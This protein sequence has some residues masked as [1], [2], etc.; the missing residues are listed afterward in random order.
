MKKDKRNFWI[1]IFLIII[2]NLIS[3]FIFSSGITNKLRGS[4]MQNDNMIMAVDDYPKI[5]FVVNSSGEKYVNENIA[6]TVNA[7][8]K[9][10]IIKLEYSFDLENWIK[11]DKSFNT[12]EISEKIVFSKNMNE[13]L[14]IRVA[15]EKGL[16]SYA[17]KT[18]LKI[19]K[20]KPIL[21][22]INDNNDIMIIAEDNVSLSKIQYSNDLMS[23]ADEEISGQDV[24]LRKENFDYKY[25]RVVDTVGNIS[26][27]K[28]TW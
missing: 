26:H 22:I 4:I 19:D 6:I 23:W 7:I 14:Y 13:Y 3:Y 28:N 18:V 24:T 15:N 10:N 20:Q 25:I 2:I 8:S 16:K 17:Y 5:N 12:K 11:I 1:L 27:V 9:Y 21:K